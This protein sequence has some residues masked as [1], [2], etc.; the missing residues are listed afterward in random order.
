MSLVAKSGVG[1][2]CRLKKGTGTQI[3]GK[4]ILGMGVPGLL[5]ENFFTLGLIRVW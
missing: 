5:K 2:T 4:E 3:S 1:V